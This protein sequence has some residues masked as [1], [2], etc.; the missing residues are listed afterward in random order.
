MTASMVP[1]SLKRKIS[2][3][4]FPSNCLV[5]RAF[6]TFKPRPGVSLSPSAGL[7]GLIAE[8]VVSAVS[9]TSVSIGPPYPLGN[10]LNAIPIPTPAESTAIHRVSF[11]MVSPWTISGSNLY[12]D[13][14]TSSRRFLSLS[15]LPCSIIGS[16]TLNTQERSPAEARHT[17]NRDNT[18]FIFIFL[19]FSILFPFFFNYTP[20]I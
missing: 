17:I 10:T 13:G 2:S 4:F 6:A 11:K 14:N 7:A 9:A 15:F 8:M 18:I 1:P 19:P 12:A 16:V 20:N 3:I 5:N